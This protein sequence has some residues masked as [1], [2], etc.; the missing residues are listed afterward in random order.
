MS[1]EHKQQDNNSSDEAIDVPSTRGGRFGIRRQYFVDDVDGPTEGKADT[2]LNYRATRYRFQYTTNETK[3]DVKWKV[4]VDCS[5][6]ELK[7]TGEELELTIRTEWVGKE[8][9]VMPYIVK[10]VGRVSVKTWCH[11]LEHDILKKDIL[12]NKIAAGEKNVNLNNDSVKALC[13]ALNELT[14]QTNIN[15]NNRLT[16]T[17]TTAIKDPEIMLRLRL[18]QNEYMNKKTGDKEYEGDCSGEIDKETILAMDKALIDKWKIKYYDLGEYT[19]GGK[20]LARV[21]GEGTNTAVFL[22][23]GLHGDELGGKR[24]IKIMKEHIKDNPNIIPANTIFYVLNPA[25][26]SIDRNINGYDANRSFCLEEKNMPKEIQAIVKLIDYF[27]ERYAALTIISGHSFF[28]DTAA[29]NS[30]GRKTE[31]KTLVFSLYKLTEQGEAEVKRVVAGR[32]YFPQGIKLSN[33]VD[34]KYHEIQQ[35]S[36]ILMDAFI[37]SSENSS[38]P[39]INEQDFFDDEI[40]Y[41]ELMYFIAEKKAEFLRKNVMKN[42]TMIEFE[43]PKSL[44]PPVVEDLWGDSFKNFVTIC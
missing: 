27:I 10:A 16:P 40:I 25:S 3:K 30:N 13:N 31:G 17:K 26:I 38:T 20:M 4:K 42:I 36:K 5:E 33:T 22:I 15:K 24:A 2:T 18:F 41:G 34:I 28:D 19:K 1:D 14:I 32:K 8:I 44:S 6:E 43:T 21:F 35:D 39:F 12:L 23:G 9:T 29:R 11:I 37:R 7:T